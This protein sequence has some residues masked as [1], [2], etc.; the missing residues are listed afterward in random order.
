MTPGLYSV[1]LQVGDEIYRRPLVIEL[2]PEHPDGRWLAAEAEAERIELEEG[3]EE[4][5]AMD[6]SPIDH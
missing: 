5:G 4:E 6:D 2:D 1:V 3:D